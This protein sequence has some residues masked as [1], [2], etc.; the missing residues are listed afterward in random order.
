VDVALFNEKIYVRIED[1]KDV[2]IKE[3]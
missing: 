2:K 3:F 1:W